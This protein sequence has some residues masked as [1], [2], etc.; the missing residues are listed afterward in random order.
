MTAL[1]VRV[2]QQTPLPRIP[3]YIAICCREWVA[4]IGYRPGRCGICRTVPVFLRKD[5]LSA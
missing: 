4:P 5:P 3:T 1:E 2:I